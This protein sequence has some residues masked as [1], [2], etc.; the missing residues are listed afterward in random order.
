MAGAPEIPCSTAARIWDTSSRARLYEKNT[1]TASTDLDGFVPEKEAQLGRAVLPPAASGAWSIAKDRRAVRTTVGY[2]A[3]E[4]N[5]TYE[6]VS[7]ARPATSR[8]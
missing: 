5:P 7:P 1:A 6:E 4:R 8:R 2:T 3:M